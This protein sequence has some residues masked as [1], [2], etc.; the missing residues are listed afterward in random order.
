MVV[1][2]GG[3]WELAVHL[4]Q[5]VLPGY[6]WQT[7]LVTAGATVVAGVLGTTCAWLVTRYE[8]PLRPLAELLL[9]APLAMPPF[10]TA[11]AFSGLLGTLFPDLETAYRVL[12]I[13]STFGLIFVLSVSLYP[14]VFLVVRHHMRRAASPTLSA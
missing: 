10:V 7:V 3:S 4:A 12:S 5:T 1:G 14:Y 6:V 2:I 13:R 11:I 8:F 9:V